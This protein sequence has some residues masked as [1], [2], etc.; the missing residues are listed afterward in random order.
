MLSNFCGFSFEG[1]ICPH[2]NKCFYLNWKSAN[3]IRIKKSIPAASFKLDKNWKK[4]VSTELLQG[5]G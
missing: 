1:S 3:S 5:S 4:I 2:I